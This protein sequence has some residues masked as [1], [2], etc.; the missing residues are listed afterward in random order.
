M[1]NYYILYLIKFYF[2][3]CSE[4]IIAQNEESLENANKYGFNHETKGKIHLNL[5]FAYRVVGKLEK[6]LIQY[7]ACLE[8]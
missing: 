5:A 7:I 2:I 8:I 3:N 1:Q 4:L 6:S